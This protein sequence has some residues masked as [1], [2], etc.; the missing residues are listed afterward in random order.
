MHIGSPV[1]LYFDVHLAS[2][3]LIVEHSLSG[4]TN[5]IE[6]FIVDVEIIS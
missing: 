2:V 1:T 4:N 3:A 6:P 5:N